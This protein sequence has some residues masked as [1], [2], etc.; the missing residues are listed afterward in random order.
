[1]EKSTLAHSRRVV[2][3]RKLRKLGIVRTVAERYK[4]AKGNTATMQCSLLG[5]ARPRFTGAG[6]IW[7]TV[8][9]NLHWAT[10]KFGSKVAYAVKNGVLHYTPGA[11]HHTGY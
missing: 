11:L 3:C 6:I 2:Q 10:K 9:A 5:C 7:H 4:T 8:A 1:M